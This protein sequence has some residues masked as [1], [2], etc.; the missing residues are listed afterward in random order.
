MAYPPPSPPYVGPPYRHSGNGNKPII[1]IV[2]HCTV[3]SDAKGAQGTARYFRSSAANGSAHY[4]VDSDETLQSAFDSVVCWHAPP[5][6]H[7]IGIELCCS[8]S[9]EG[10]G[11]WQRDDH[12]AM[13]RR[14]ARLTA[15]L[16]LAYDLPVRKMTVA[17]V[18]SN[19]S[20]ICG[21]I[22][23][24][25]AFHQSS[26]WDPG[27][28]FPWSQFMAM[29]RAEVSAITNPTTPPP[30]EEDMPLTQ[31]DAKLVVDELLN[32][33]LSNGTSFAGNITETADRVEV[34]YGRTGTLIEGGGINS[35]LD[36][37]HGLN[38]EAKGTLGRIET[39]VNQPI[40]VV[41]LAAAIVAA[42]PTDGDV[43]QATVEA[44]VRAVL[45]TLD[46]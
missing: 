45:G 5:N 29:V 40:D 27:P 46:N 35:Q 39:K 43:D 42:M 15:E 7:S 16:C 1:R 33:G 6:T 32:R 9:N 3:G 38:V 4:I 26:H 21:H 19:E 22:D 8:L 41:A 17:Q 2:V 18:R 10:E 13:L 24:S 36:A 23:V 31:A 28:H 14:A 20:G 30:P 25:N 34:I 12:Q 37:M 11:H 44:G